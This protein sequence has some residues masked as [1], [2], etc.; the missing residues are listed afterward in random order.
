VYW[1]QAKPGILST[2][3][4]PDCTLWVE[5]VVCCGFFLLLFVSVS[6]WSV[7]SINL[8]QAWSFVG[9]DCVLFVNSLAFDTLPFKKK[10]VC[11]L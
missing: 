7:L 4:I 2:I 10:F 6:I 3:L 8:F 11:I 9:C 5:H 1:I